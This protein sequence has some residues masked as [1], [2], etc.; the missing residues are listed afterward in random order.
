[1]VTTTTSPM[2]MVVAVAVV[3]GVIMMVVLIIGLLMLFACGIV[4]GWPSLARLGDA[5]R[6]EAGGIEP[7]RTR[8]IPKLDLRYLIVYLISCMVMYR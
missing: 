5:D 3:M 8:Q 1:M 2:M 6:P 7:D 4:T